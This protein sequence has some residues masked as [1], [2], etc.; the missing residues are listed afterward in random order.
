M[1][2]SRTLILA[3]S[4]AVG[5]G[6][7]SGAPARTVNGASTTSGGSTSGPHSGGSAST[8]GG[9]SPTSGGL[10]SVK[11]PASGGSGGAVNMAFSG[12]A[13]SGGTPAVPPTGAAGGSSPTNPMIPAAGN[14]GLGGELNGLRWE[15]LCRENLPP[16]SAACPNVP[17]D[18]MCPTDKADPSGDRQGYYSTDTTVTFPGTPGVVYN[19]GIRVRGVVEFRDYQNGQHDGEHFYVGGTAPDIVQTAEGS[20]EVHLNLY[21]LEIS[22]PHQIYFLNHDGGLPTGTNSPVGIVDQTKTIQIEGGATVHAVAFDRNC[23]AYSNCESYDGP[24]APILVPGVAPYPAAFSGQ[25]LQLDVTS[26]TPKN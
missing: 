10:P 11:P 13:A 5:S 23:N 22:A 25:F 19:V 8:S 12:G 14:S 21:S 26:V 2:Y 20:E 6:C 7:S 17:A 9:A 1:S 16:G 18:G 4:A 15:A 24:C 3:V